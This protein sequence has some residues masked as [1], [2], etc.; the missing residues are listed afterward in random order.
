MVSIPVNILSYQE[1]VLLSN[2]FNKDILNS[3]A[4]FS[5]ETKDYRCPQEPLESDEVK[6]W[7]RTGKSNVDKVFLCSDKEKRAMALDYS[8]GLF[9]YYICEVEPMT[10]TLR[11]Y[12][13]IQKDDETFIYSRL[14][15]VRER[16]PQHDF[17]LLRN[18]VTPDWAKGAVIYQIFV[19]RFYN[20][21]KEND[22]KSNE[23]IYLGR[24]V[25][26]IED[27]NTL[28]ATDDI[29]NFYGG[30]LQ[31][32]IEK[33]AY[34]KD[35]GVEVIYFNPIFV[36]PSNHKYD[37]QDYD[38]VDPHIG[39]IIEDGGNPL[40]FEKFNNRHAT[41]YI[42]RTTE[43]V[44]LEA[45]NQLF[46]SL[47]KIAHEH[48]IKIILDGV[49]NHCGAFNKWLD[50]EGFYSSTGKYPDGAYKSQESPYNN[51][52]RWYDINNWP[53][54]DC[55]DGWWGY[56]NHPKLNYENSPE[57]YQYIMEVGK[58]W[59][60]PPYNAD[61]WRLD[62]AADLGYSEEFN[63][64]FWRDFR[65]SVKEA[66]PEA[67]ILAEHYG[68]ASAWL[69]GDQWDTVMNYDAFMEPISWFL[70]GMEKHSE[71]YSEDLFCNGQSFENAMKWNMARMGI[72]SIQTAMNELSNHDH[73]R[74]YT[75]TNKTVG[76]LHTVGSEAADKNTNKG[77][78][79]EAV[80]FQMTWPGAPTVYY[81]DEAGLTGWTD[82][83]NRRSF[84]W[85]KEDKELIEFHKAMIQIH[86][87]YS[88]FRTGSVEFLYTD[89]GIISFGRF[90]KKEQFVIVLNNNAIEKQISIPVWSIGIGLYSIMERLILTDIES[91]YV[92][93]KE[94]KVE[95][96]I[97]T[98]TLPPY[99]SLVLK[100]RKESQKKYEAKNHL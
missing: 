85:G 20:G 53:N 94:Y 43:F 29:R 61:G 45:S 8:E 55:Y 5:D 73:S 30:D 54:N 31:G 64:Q 33:M 19:D 91:F 52:F 27:W 74:F 46:I 39:V 15:L 48:Q 100:N 10:E 4:I 71:S 40:V 49:F 63:H 25:Q 35:L 13:E 14:G 89:Y 99:S 11:Y 81:G 37:T 69:Q 6:V 82:P 16:N 79:Q 67:I 50:R 2:R 92:E 72:Q 22:V 83:D 12:F 9:D 78:M 98:V 87:K 17:A 75:R 56:D 28:P 86:K 51:Y 41:M 76:R 23:Y 3:R 42:Q 1:K 34:L 21:R 26:Q 59:V 84:P 93:P 77:I 38:Y 66:N 96:G 18:F 90:D 70:T 44:N 7:I 60:S 36:S 24:P 80:V 62:V 95:A 65:K 88:A 32:V 97:L 68:D 57:L 58:K 47:V